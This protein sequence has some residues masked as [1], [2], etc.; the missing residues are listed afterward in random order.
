M[1]TLTQKYNWV[2]TDIALKR[3]GITAEKFEDLTKE[4]WEVLV[5]NAKGDEELASLAVR[6]YFS[7]EGS[8][9]LEEAGYEDDWE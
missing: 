2:I 3:K 9:L 5:E 1:A 7:H 6:G 4:N 8:D